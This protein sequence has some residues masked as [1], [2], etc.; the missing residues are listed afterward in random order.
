MLVNYQYRLYPDSAQKNQLNSWLRI[1]RYWYNWQLGDRFDWWQNNR[2]PINSCPL[3]CPL[4]ELRDKPNKYSQKKLASKF[5]EDLIKVGYS[6]ELL[7]FKK[8]PSQTLQDV[9]VRVDKAFSRFISGDKNGKR[10]GKPRFK[11][12][13][14]YRTLKIE[15]EGQALKVERIE[16]N[17]MFVSISK[18]KGWLKVRLHRPLLQGFT[19]KNALITKKANGWYITFCLEDKTIPAFNPDEVIPTW[20]NTLGMDAVLHEDDYLA[21]SEGTKLPALKSFR[22]S[23]KRLAKVSRKKATK[24]KG[25]RQRRKLAKRESRE[26]QRIARSRKDHAY[27]TAHAL[28]RTGK[29]VFVHEKLNL[30]GLSTRNKAKQDEYG[31]YLPNGQRAKSGLNKS[32]KDA[33]FGNFFNT[34]QYIAEKAGCKVIAVNPAYT[35][36]ML[37]YRDEFVFTDCSIREYFDEEIVLMIDRDINAGINIKKVGLELF[38]TIKRRKG[39]P[40][41]IDNPITYSTLKEVVRPELVSQSA[42]PILR[43]DSHLLPSC[44]TTRKSWRQYRVSNE[45]EICS[46][47]NVAASRKG[48]F[49]KGARGL[50]RY[51]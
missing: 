26:H 21:T 27:K 43:G 32:W 8:V 38:P 46:L 36:Q 40:H 19:I 39:K 37:S 7:N 44:K 10:S 13:A 30:Q 25:S 20:D 35:S 45:R 15:G 11:N 42:E 14:R 33:A 18:L 2:S 9:S 24:K 16:K 6:G 48:Q 17:Y 51:R 5:K 4:P 29:K 34:L 31:N 12:E 23:E 49:R 28:I 41:V 1:A 47:T 3:I 50:S 22:K